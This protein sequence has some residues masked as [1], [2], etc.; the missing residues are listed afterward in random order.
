MT[1]LALHRRRL[2]GL[3]YRMTGSVA[4]AEDVVQETFLRA[5]GHPPAG[6][7]GP[8]L[9]TVAL[10]LA[11]DRLRQRKREAY[12]GPWLPAPIDVAELELEPPS[13][14]DRTTEA[15][16]SMLES[17][18]FAFLLALEA[19]TPRERAV[20]LLRDVLDYSAKETAAAIESTEGAVK[21]QLL[22]AR[23]KIAGYE[24]TRAARDF[25]TTQAALVA[26]LT[27]LRAEDTHAIEALLAEDA[28]AKTDAGGEFLA[29]GID[30]VGPERI[31]RALVG[32]T[33]KAPPLLHFELRALNGLPFVVGAQAARSARDA[34]RFAIG[35]ELDA[36]G[37]IRAFY[38]V[39]ATAK[40]VGVR[41]A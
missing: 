12:R 35:C 39:L 28:I 11:R 5:L 6:E 27:A 16:Y 4:D 22:R 21:V 32:V 20:L 9:V 40:L 25:A 1:D 38:T 18:S 3:A 14:D 29:A 15:R 24:A 13:P 2:L 7:L 34:P 26:F 41:G 36:H 17:V 19:L 33:R 10:N 37:K 30:L 31:R 23:R 8:W